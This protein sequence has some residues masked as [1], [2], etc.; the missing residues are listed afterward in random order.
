MVAGRGQ[1]GLRGTQRAHTPP[2]PVCGQALLGG[3]LPLALLLALQQVHSAHQPHQ[4]PISQLM[5]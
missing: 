5:R 3:G 2:V 4:L 1:D